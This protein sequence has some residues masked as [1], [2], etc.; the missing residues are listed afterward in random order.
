MKDNFSEIAAEYA[1]FRPNYPD[2]M[3]DYILS[4]V[5][6]RNAALDIATGNGQVAQKLSKDFANV[7]ATDISA[8]QISQSGP[9]KNITYR[10]EPAEKTSFRDNQFDLI[11]VAQGVHWFEFE[12]F[13][14]E[15]YRIL[16]PDGIFAALGYGLFSTN[17]ETDII[18]RDFYYNIVGPFWDAERK[19]IDEMYRTIPFPFDEIPVKPF[20]NRLRW[21]FAELSGYLQT[22]SAVRHYKIATGKDPVAEISAKLRKSWGNG[23]NEVVFPLLLRIGKVPQ[24]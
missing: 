6:R 12:R 8:S 24:K 13:Y 16:K 23:T 20:E 2:A 4:F 14:A 19:Y 7:Y 9:A 11:T 18:L 5:S 3:I 1:K 17:P 22:W 10:V 15:V 21:D